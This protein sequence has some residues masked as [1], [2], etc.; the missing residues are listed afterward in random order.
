MSVAYRL[1]QWNRHKRVYD[2][3]LVG[4]VG[5]YLAAFV[6]VSSIVHAGSAAISPEIMMMRALGSCAIV[7]LHVVLCIGPLHRLS[8]VFAPLLYNRRHLGVTLFLVALAHAVLALGFYGGFGVRN[9]LLALVDRPAGFV[10]ISRVPFELFGF[11]ALLVLFL[12]AATSHDFWLKNLSPRWWKALHMG[13]YVAYAMLVLH[14][15]LGSMQAERGALI[16]VLLI[17]GVVI[18]S[19][20]HVAAGLRQWRRDADEREPSAWVDVADVSEISD[21]RAK[22]VCVRG[23]ERVAIFRDGATLSAVS[24]VCAHQGGPLG[25][26]KIVGGCVTC[27]WHGYQ[28]LAANGQSPPPY[29]EKIATYELRVSGSRVLL[30]PV[31]KAPG[32]PVEPARIGGA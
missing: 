17:A 5:A 23:G 9:P 20:L 27:P 25:E 11:I 4:G 13:V 15:A 12:M 1:V 31:A 3:W 21:T 14:V 7:L 24:N 10:A 30:N 19:G 8:P 22:V 28:Y 32:T 18:V 16:P 29:T 2:A 6:L 26:G